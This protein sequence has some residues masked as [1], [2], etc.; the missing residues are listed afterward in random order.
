MTSAGIEPAIPGI[1]SRQTYATDASTN[2]I[3]LIIYISII[4]GF[5]VHKH[6]RLA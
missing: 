4:S 5:T 3:V 2:G 1:E 6:R